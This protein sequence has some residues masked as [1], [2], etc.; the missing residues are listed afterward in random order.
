MTAIGQR[1]SLRVVREA[2]PGLYLDGEELG[3]ILMPKRYVPPG[4]VRGD[5]LEV[6]VHRDSED[7]LVATTEIPR[8]CVGEFAALIVV[9]LKARIGA[10]L[11]WGLTKDLFLPLREQGRRVAIGD[12]VVVYVRLDEKSSRIVATTRFERYLDRTP[13]PYKE[14]DRVHLLI[15]GESPL[16]Y[17]AI[18]ENAHL[19]L[20]FKSDLSAPIPI[21]EKVEGYVRAVRPDGK[22]DLSLNRAGYDRVR[23]LTDQI[24]AALQIAGGRLA[25]SDESSPAEI[26][27][28]FGTSKKAFKQALGALYR[29]RRIRLSENGIELVTPTPA[30]HTARQAAPA[31][32]GSPVK[33]CLAAV[34]HVQRKVHATTRLLPLQTLHCPHLRPP[35]G[36][37]RPSVRIAPV[38]LG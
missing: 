1:N 12:T 37:A 2:P 32:Q 27:A 13:A 19:G 31:S 3:E 5:T 22:I 30:Q 18:V 28:Q 29:R 38:L 26:R 8:A 11:E 9:G 6:F 17:K 34:V 4:T 15:A 24:L 23:P 21:G 14:G 10:F 16:G 33:S 7:R 20:L 35:A 25:F 36:P